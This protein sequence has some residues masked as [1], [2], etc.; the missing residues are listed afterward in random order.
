MNVFRGGEEQDQGEV[1]EIKI[2]EQDAIKDEPEL[3]QTILFTIEPKKL[4]PLAL[5]NK[6]SKKVRRKRPNDDRVYKL[7]PVQDTTDGITR[8]MLAP[9]DCT[10]VE[11]L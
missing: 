7:N 8:D 11:N 6:R 5:D 4:D 1:E 10:R 9:D 3:S 2:E